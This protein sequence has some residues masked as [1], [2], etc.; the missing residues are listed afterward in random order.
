[1]KKSLL[2]I[3]GLLVIA[4]GFISCR[5]DDKDPWKEFVTPNGAM[6]LLDE[7][8]VP[9]FDVTALSTATYEGEL[10]DPI[11]NVA[12]MQLRVSLNGGDLFDLRTITEFPHS[13][14]VSASDVANALGLANVDELS[15]GDKVTMDNIIT[16]DDGVAFTKEDLAD[17]LFGNPGQ[18]QGFEITTFVSCP[19][20]AAEAAGTYDIVTDP[21]GTFLGSGT[22]ITAVVG[23]DDTQII[24]QDMFSHPNPTTGGQYDIAVDVVA[25]S[26]EATVEKQEAWHCDNFGCGF[27]QASV[28]TAGSGNFFFS[29]TGFLTVNLRHTVSLGSFGIFKM[30]LQKQ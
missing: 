12:S 15:A 7:V 26:G 9:V 22:G 6:I 1:M 2:N 17:D 18:R 21:F 10:R 14:V 19:F 5:D 23:A 20:S 8:K 24:F 3:I 4:F 13:L 28:E 11:G 30:E 25:S 16:R 27:G 29:C